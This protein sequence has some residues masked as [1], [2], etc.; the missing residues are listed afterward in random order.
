M[1]V[2][3]K[4][5]ISYYKSKKEIFCWLG[6]DFSSKIFKILIKNFDYEPKLIAVIVITV[7]KN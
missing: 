6:D 1:L 2:K 7:E 5:S 4:I 3:E